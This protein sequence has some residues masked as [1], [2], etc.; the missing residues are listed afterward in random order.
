MQKEE[1]ERIKGA[2]GRA[3]VK[4]PGNKILQDMERMIL[5]LEHWRYALEDICKR[6]GPGLDGSPENASGLIARKALEH[7]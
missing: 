3:I 7:S 2:V 5:T 6:E 1:I 4:D